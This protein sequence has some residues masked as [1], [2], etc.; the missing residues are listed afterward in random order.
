MVQISPRCEVFARKNEGKKGATGL[1]VNSDVRTSSQ[2]SIEV[3]YFCPIDE[4]T[5]KAGGIA[6]RINN[7]R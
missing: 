4:H 5:A 1:R 6:G 7:R 2:P 3:D